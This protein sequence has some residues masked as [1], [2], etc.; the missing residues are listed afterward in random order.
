[1]VGCS[2]LYIFFDGEC[3]V[4][5]TSAEWGYL[6]QTRFVWIAFVILF[7]LADGMCAK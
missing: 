2:I 4:A 6:W 5:A 1:M 7:C 3:F